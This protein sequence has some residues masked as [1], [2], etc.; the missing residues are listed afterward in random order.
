M[1]QTSDTKTRAGANM[2]GLMR[3]VAPDRTGSGI[4]QPVTNA[5]RGLNTF[6]GI[7]KLNVAEI[8][9]IAPES[10]FGRYRG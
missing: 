6:M 4:Y 9:P 5:R 7:D 3:G 2:R 1:D 8:V 10:T